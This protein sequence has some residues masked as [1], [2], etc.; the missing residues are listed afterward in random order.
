M[1]AVGTYAPPI[2]QYGYL[3]HTFTGGNSRSKNLQVF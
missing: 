1:Y 3:F 2:E